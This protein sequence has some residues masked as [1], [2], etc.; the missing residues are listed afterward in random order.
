MGDYFDGILAKYVPKSRQ[1]TQEVDGDDVV[2][3]IVYEFN[4]IT[5]ADKDAI[6]AILTSM[7][8]DFGDKVKVSWKWISGRRLMR[9]LLAD[10]ATKQTLAVTIKMKDEAT[11]K[12]LEENVALAK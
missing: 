10:P 4:A 8:K 7:Q 9:R 2:S 11:A 6:N 1:L 12:Q 3:Q 5:Q